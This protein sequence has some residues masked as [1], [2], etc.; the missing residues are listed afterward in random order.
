LVDFALWWLYAH[1]LKNG[2]K[3]LL[4]IHYFKD[5]GVRIIVL[6]KFAFKDILI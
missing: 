3:A 6:P 5:V 2:A 4:T 1:V